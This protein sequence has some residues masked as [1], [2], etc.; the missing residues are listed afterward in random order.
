M[1]GFKSLRASEHRNI[2][3]KS[4]FAYKL[5]PRVIGACHRRQL[6]VRPF[7]VFVK[8]RGKRENGPCGGRVADGLAGYIAY[9]GPKWPNYRA[10]FECVG[11]SANTG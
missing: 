9:N 4:P 11:W 8:K 1:D 2:A 3:R 6:L 10:N 5:R 7:I